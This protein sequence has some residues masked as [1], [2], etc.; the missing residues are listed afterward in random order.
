MPI[1]RKVLRIGDSKGI[2]FPKSWIEFLERDGSKLKEVAIEVD[3][4][5]KII[6]ILPVKV[7]VTK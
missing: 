2:T 4:E 5:L 7:Q 3:G 6:P 1:V